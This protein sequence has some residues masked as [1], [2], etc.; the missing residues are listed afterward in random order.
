[1]FKTSSSPLWAKD[2]GK[3]TWVLNLAPLCPRVIR[4][5]ISLLTLPDEGKGVE[6]SQKDEWFHRLIL[7]RFGDFCSPQAKGFGKIQL[8]R[9]NQNVSLHGDVSLETHQTCDRCALSFD[10]ALEIH[11]TRHLAPYFENP[12]QK[13][14]EEEETELSEED[15]N[16]SYYHGEEIDLG[17]ILAEEVFLA[18]PMTFLCREDCRGLC[19]NCGKNLNQGPCPC[20]QAPEGSPFS[21]LKDLKLKS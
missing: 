14:D 19:P 18:I 3:A 2:G 12:E 10:R 15:L 21:A 7:D 16:F 9:T 8:W 20:E 1:M 11:L 6:F 4:M 5:K 17:N 13:A